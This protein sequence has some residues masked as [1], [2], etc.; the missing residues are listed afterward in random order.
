ML[1]SQKRLLPYEAL[2]AC[3]QPQEKGDRLTDKPGDWLPHMTSLPSVKAKVLGSSTLKTRRWVESTAS[4]GLFAIFCTTGMILVS[5]FH[6]LFMGRCKSRCL[7][8]KLVRGDEHEPLTAEKGRCP[9]TF[10]LN[11][12][13]TY[14][15]YI[16]SLGTS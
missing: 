10:T 13:E 1:P 2:S 5:L 15:D 14:E 4:C 12:K 16:W 9:A 11:R 8:D 3:V 7:T 6:A